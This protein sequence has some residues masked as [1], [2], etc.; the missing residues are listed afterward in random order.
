M[1]YLKFDFRR[2]NA[3]SLFVIFK[4]LEILP[5]SHFYTNKRQRQTDIIEKWFIF[6]VFSFLLSKIHHVIYTNIQHFRRWQKHISREYKYFATYFGW[7]LID[8]SSSSV[9][10]RA[11]DFTNVNESHGIFKLI[12]SSWML[13]YVTLWSNQQN[14]RR[15]QTK[16]TKSK[17]MVS[18]DRQHYNWSNAKDDSL[19]TSG[20]IENCIQFS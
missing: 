15:N 12:M 7:W 20:N 3:L 4:K 18:V 10:L 5:L 6:F 16:T 13:R 1:C 14:I 8:K 19:S 11:W 9:T 17:Q 2:Q